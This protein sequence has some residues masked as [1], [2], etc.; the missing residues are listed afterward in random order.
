MRILVFTSY[1]LPAKRA[2]G[3]IKTLKNIVNK[4]SPHGISFDI[5]T[6]DRDIGDKYRFHSVSKNSWEAVGKANVFYFSNGLSKLIALVRDKKYSFLYINSFFS[7]KFSIVP[8]LLARLFNRKV[9]IAPRGE[10][11]DGALRI[12][13]LKKKSY[14]AV[15]KLLLL[16]KNVVFHASTV[17]ERDDIKEIFGDKVDIVIAENIPNVE[18]PKICRVKDNDK[19]RVAFLSRISE[20]KN[21]LFA[22]D[23]L[24][25][26]ATEIEFDIFGPVED[27]SYW[28]QCQKLIHRLPNRIKTNYR[29]MLEPSKVISTL[30]DYDLFFLPT[31]GENYGHAIVEAL[32][33]GL[34]VLISDKTPWRNLEELGLGWDV[35]LDNRQKFVEAINKTAAASSADHL[36]MRKNISTWASKQFARPEIE[37]ANLTMFRSLLERFG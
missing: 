19:L 21:L 30:A 15:Y 27:D 34:P 26:A 24:S 18:S 14:I 12:R 16:H 35:A 29:G 10:F 37:E 23:V 2:G 22:L 36:T 3:P 25:D 28:Q 17:H 11:S 9:L 32:C 20:K 31:L 1:Y 6:S 4:I 5:V 13:Y 33:A 8:Q 7:V